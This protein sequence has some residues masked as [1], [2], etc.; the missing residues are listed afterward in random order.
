MPTAFQQLSSEA[1]QQLFFKPVG[2][3]AN[4]N[5]T[6]FGR[7]NKILCKLPNRCRKEIQGKYFIFF[8]SACLASICISEIHCCL[9]CV[10]FF[11]LVCHSLKASNS[12]SQCPTNSFH[13]WRP[14]PSGP[15]ILF[16]LLIPILHFFPV[17]SAVCQCQT[18]GQ[19]QSEC[20]PALDATKSIMRSSLSDLALHYLYHSMILCLFV[21]PVLFFFFFS[22]V[23]EKSFALPEISP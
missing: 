11:P 5:M 23:N 17:S 15:P 22:P 14:P 1:G 7:R 16:D 12:A 13:F 4:R 6:S 19:R 20:S 21:Q 10:V 3:P 2:K 8:L 9:I 18:R